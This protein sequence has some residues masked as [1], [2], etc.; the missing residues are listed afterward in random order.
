MELA[1]MIAAM[2]IGIFGALSAIGSKEE[3]Q[4]KAGVAL[5]AMGLT[6]MVFLI[7]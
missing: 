2:V 3:S 6:A 4:Q 1:G 7:K 5:V